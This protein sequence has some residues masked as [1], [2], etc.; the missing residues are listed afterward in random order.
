[1]SEFKQSGF[2]L[3]EL[4]VVLALAIILATV[5]AISMNSR[6]SI[7]RVESA[8]ER[9]ASDLAYARKAALFK[10]CPTRVI[11]CG[12]P[13]CQQTGVADGANNVIG[14]GGEP[15]RFYGILRLSQDDT[16]GNAICPN[17]DW[18]P[19]DA[20]GFIHWDFDRK[21]QQ[22]S[23]GAGVT[24]IYNGAGGV[25]DSSNDFVPGEGDAAEA[26]S[27]W[28]PTTF[29]ATPNVPVDDGTMSADFDSAQIYFQIQLDDCEPDD[30]DSD[31]LGILVGLTQ[32]G[33]ARVVPCDAGG[34]TD[35]T[36]TCY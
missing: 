3:V 35:A 25:M 19:E 12:D 16:L 21:P 4:M 32:G 24:A 9:I 27:L 1:M 17:P 33:E 22:I 10:G 31:C 11:L 23:R 36:E 15:A 20:D 29:E 6:V 14:V 13:N 28:F 8:A 7:S 2:T 34:R 5:G 18:V 30:A 26:T